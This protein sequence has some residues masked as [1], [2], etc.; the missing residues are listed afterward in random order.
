MTMNRGYWVAAALL[1]AG[2]IAPASAQ[3]IS[4]TVDCA[5]GQSIEQ[6]VTRGDARKPLL[7]IVRG[8]CNESVTISRDNVTLRGDPELGGTVVGVA[9]RDTILVY[10]NWVELDELTIVGGTTGIRLQ[11]P[12]FAGVYNTHV[13][14]TTGPGIGVRAGDIAI[15]GTTVERA[16]T[17][18]LIMQRGASAR[19]VGSRFW[20]SNSSGLYVETNSTINVNASQIGGNGGHGVEIVSGSWG[21][22][23]GTQIVDNE[24]GILVRS[25]QALIGPNNHIASNRQH[26]VLAEAGGTADLR[27]N[28]ITSNYHNGV[29]GHLGPTLVLHGN[30][31]SN[32]SESG[33]FCSANCTLQIGGAGIT[34]N[35]QH[36]VLV[37]LGSML[38]LEG[39]GTTYADW[40]G[41]WGVWCGDKES[42]VS[43][44]EYFSGSV[45]DT[46]TGF[47]D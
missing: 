6:A 39:P 33:V 24:T 10:A 5:S 8:T 35:G 21:S 37:R 26:G 17:S 47:D 23:A 14:D 29:S 46:C 12:F 7:V 9:G 3:T 11:G 28:T 15:I 31:I 34:G 42:S 20:G 30:E 45:S 41:W 27:S 36:G 16:G 44:L 32:N 19:I 4:F 1:V 18:A 2:M 38:I 40:N 25:S 43:G 13:M 22:I